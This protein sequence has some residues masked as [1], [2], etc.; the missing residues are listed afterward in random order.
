MRIAAASDLHYHRNSK[1]AAKELFTRA[2]READVL[3]LGGDLT[4]YGLPE[5]AHVLAE[6]IHAYCRVPIVAVLGNH[7]FE[8]AQTGE[9][10]RILETAGVRMLDG[11]CLEMGDVGFVGVCGFGG[12]FGPR[13]LNAW[14]EPAIKNFV[15]ESVD[16]A[17]K[18]ERALS[19]LKTRHRIALLHY[20]PIRETVTGEDPEIFPFLGSTRLE[21]PLNRFQVDAAFHGHAHNGKLDGHT[22]TGIPVFNV[23]P[24]I[25]KK[26]GLGSCFIFQLASAPKT[27]DAVEAALI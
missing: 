27:A 5:E 18:L 19:R 14:G 7:D 8:A 21:G 13:M 2:S 17:M 16:Q 9:V 15:Q 25:L 22:S 1:G 24:A 6:D 23:A 4:D 11:E 10:I 3:L 26:A 12:G 20:A